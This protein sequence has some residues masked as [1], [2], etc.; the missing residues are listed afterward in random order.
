MIPSPFE[1]P[2]AFA[3]C[4]CR[5]EAAYQCTCRATVANVAFAP[6]AGLQRRRRREK[7]RLRRAVPDATVGLRRRRN[8]ETRR[9]GIMRACPQRGVADEEPVLPG[10]AGPVVVL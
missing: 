1:S 8:V 3:A 10:R 2:Q 5:F 9:R 4:S 7:E 6:S